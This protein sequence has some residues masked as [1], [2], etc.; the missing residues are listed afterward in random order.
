[1]LMRLSVA[2]LKPGMYVAEITRQT[3][4][5]QVRTE[6]HLRDQESISALT[7]L[8]IVEVMVD[9]ARQQTDVVPAARPVG[10]NSRTS[11]KSQQQSKVPFELELTRANQLYDEALLALEATLRSSTGTKLAPAASMRELIQQFMASLLRNPHALMCLAHLREGNRYLLEHALNCS[12]L[13]TMFARYCALPE[14]EVEALALGALWHDIGKIRVDEAILAKP[15]RLTADE[16]RQ[17]RKHVEYG[18]ELTSALAHLPASTRAAIAEH[19]E[20]LD[21]NGYPAKRRG[22]EISLA[23]R[24]MAIVDSYDAL[25]G[26]RA[27]RNPVTSV[28]AFKVLRADSYALYDAE[29]VMSF[30]KAIGFYPAGTLVKLKS[31]RLAMVIA[32]HPDK[33]YS[34]LV[35]VFYHGR[36]RQPLPIQELDLAAAD[37]EDDIEAAV[38]PEQFKLDLLQFFRSAVLLS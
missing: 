21:G 8:G 7:S 28:R 10:A 33:P 14:A 16:L 30:I 29:L 4:Q 25:T 9:P 2:E 12:V 19:H 20:R 27:Y 26:Y 1:M 32:T 31:Q 13:M 34:P 18:V 37:C 24:M 17:M 3:G 11:T 35:K 36:F 15:A 22:N 38:R 6:G 5:M 23:G